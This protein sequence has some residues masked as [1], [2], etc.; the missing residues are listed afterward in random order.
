VTDREI[1]HTQNKKIWNPCNTI[2]SRA[3]QAKQRPKTGRRGRPSNQ[4]WL[5]AAVK[6][7]IVRKQLLYTFFI[8][9]ESQ[10]WLAV[11]LLWLSTYVQL[12]SFVHYVYCT[13]FIIRSRHLC[14]VSEAG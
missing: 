5:I 10:V 8:W 1:V 6:I 11:W 9:Q 2:Q 14:V 7:T 12:R 4:T 13:N 3:E